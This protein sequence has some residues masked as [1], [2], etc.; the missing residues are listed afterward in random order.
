MEML[1]AK[2]GLQFKI[3]VDGDIPVEIVGDE[4]RLRQ[5]MINLM[6][7]AIK[8]TR[9]G[10]V[11]VHLL[12]PTEEHWAIRVQ[13]TGMGIP[14]E[15]HGYIFEAFRQVD[16]AITRDNR[17]IG[18]GLSIT[19]QLVELMDG[20]IILESEPGKGSTFTIILPIN[21]GPGEKP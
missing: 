20:R 5:I 3:S 12:R 1:A 8:F 4:R 15:A 16:S 9:E 6:G 17:G 7:N 14:G 11:S 19:K 21:K 18:L 10:V 13:D 2:K